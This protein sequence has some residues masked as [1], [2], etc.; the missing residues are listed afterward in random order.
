MRTYSRSAEILGRNREFIPGGVVSVNRAAKPEIAFVRG[1]GAHIWDEEGNR[2]VDYHAAFAAHFLG[3]NDA[4][5]NQA[6]E[7]TLSEAQS[8][9]GS[10]TTVQEGLLAELICQH[11]PFVDSVQFLNTGS[12]AT[13]QAIHPSAFVQIAAIAPEGQIVECGAGKNMRG[14]EVTHRT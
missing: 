5:V 3:H 8:L 11:V 10:G 2:Y 12:E 13:Y 7:R 4:S 6:I 1:Q 9:F 14:I